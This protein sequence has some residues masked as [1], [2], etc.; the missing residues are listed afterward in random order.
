MSSHTLRGCTSVAQTLQIE[1]LRIEV[2]CL[3]LNLFLITN[4]V[5]QKRRW[6][7][8]S[9]SLLAFSLL[10]LNDERVYKCTYINDTKM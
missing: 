10:G 4:T 5:T 2:Y 7:R 1:E 3:V 6:S 8:Y 9:F